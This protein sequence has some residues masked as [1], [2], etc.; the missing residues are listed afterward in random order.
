[1][2]ATLLLDLARR[3]LGDNVLKS[4][5]FRG[6]SPAICGEMLHLMLRSKNAAFELGAFAADGRK[7]VEASAT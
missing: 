6:V 5:V 4:F 1:L 7:V 2:T 3:E